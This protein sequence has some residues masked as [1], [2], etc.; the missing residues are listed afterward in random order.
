MNELERT[1][2]ALELAISSLEKNGHSFGIFGLEANRSSTEKTLA[3]INAILQPEPEFEDVAVVVWAAYDRDGGRIAV[4]DSKEY[5]EKCDGC[6]AVSELRGTLRRP[7]PQK[8]ERS[9]SVEM[10]L[11]GRSAEPRYNCS[12]RICFP[13][14]EGKQVTLTATWEEEA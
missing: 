7:K 4:K 11:I 1:K 13:G 3:N 14:A 5:A 9:V 8:V 6:V 2:K 10:V 12:P